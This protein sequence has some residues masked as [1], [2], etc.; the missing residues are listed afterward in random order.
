MEPSFLNL[1]AFVSRGMRSSTLIFLNLV[2]SIGADA[3][4]CPSCWVPT[5]DPS[6]S[7]DPSTSADPSASS[8]ASVVAVAADQPGGLD[9]S[10]GQ[11]TSG[12]TSLRTLLLL[13]LILLSLSLLLLL[14]HMV[15]AAVVVEEEDPPT[16]FF[17]LVVDW[18]MPH[19]PQPSSFL[20]Q[21]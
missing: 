20:P 4:C 8:S 18:L 15:A 5:S 13:M 3:D 7:A 10:T 6:A 16:S 9:H 21:Q 11:P 14:L 1:K 19:P 2:V 17:F 12:G